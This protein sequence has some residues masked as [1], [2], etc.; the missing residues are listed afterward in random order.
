MIPQIGITFLK[1]VMYD[2]NLEDNTIGKSH[3]LPLKEEPFDLIKIMTH[4]HEKCFG[5]AEFHL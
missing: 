4:S 1:Y 2:Y 5:H 3:R